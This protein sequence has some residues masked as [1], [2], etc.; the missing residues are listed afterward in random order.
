[1]NMPGEFAEACR[2]CEQ[3]NDEFELQCEHGRSFRPLEILIRDSDWV[4]R[5]MGEG[6]WSSDEDGRNENDPT[7]EPLTDYILR[8]M[9]DI[10]DSFKGIRLPGELPT[11]DDLRKPPVPELAGAL[12]VVLYF[13]NDS[14][15]EEFIEAVKQEKPG[16]IAKKL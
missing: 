11:E 2:L 5:F 1:M 6:I 9:R 4:V 13:Q 15:R 7:P 14:D 8:E 3:L 12:P 10:L 16:M